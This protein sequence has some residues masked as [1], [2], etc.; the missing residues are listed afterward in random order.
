[1]IILEIISVKLENFTE[2]K[3][4]AVHGCIELKPLYLF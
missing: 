4:G 1:M 2:C 3:S